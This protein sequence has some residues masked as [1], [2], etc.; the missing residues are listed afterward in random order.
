MKSIKYIV[1]GAILSISRLAFGEGTVD[2][3]IQSW[4]TNLSMNE[5]IDYCY[6]LLEDDLIIQEAFHPD[7][8]EVIQIEKKECDSLII[9]TTNPTV[10]GEISESGESVWI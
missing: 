7:E 2:S 5:K 9:P 1:M 8:W 3:K 10:G 4:F 6:D